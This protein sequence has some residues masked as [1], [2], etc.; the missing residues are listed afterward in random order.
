VDEAPDVKKVQVGPCTVAYH[1]SGAGTG[2]ILAHCSSASHRMWVPL[3]TDLQERYR[4]L[5]PDLIGYGKSDRWPA[6]Q[7]FDPSLD[8][9]VLVR[10]AQM[11]NGPVHIAAHSYGAAAALEAARQIADRVISLTLIEPVAFHLLPTAGRAEEWA[12]ISTIADGVWRA[13]SRGAGR[14]AAGIYMRFW[15]GRMRWWLMPRRQ[16]SRIIDTVGK[17]AAEFDGMRWVSTIPSDYQHIGAPTILMVGGRTRRPAKAVVEVLASNLPK[18]H[19]EVIP[20][21]GH[22]S[23]FTHGDEVRSKIITHINRQEAE[24]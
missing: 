24:R 11:V 19:V 4:V 13:A 10:L 8:A 23:P 16:R 17:V 3:I 22:M 14:V 2:V 20:T 6:D 1:D 18:A 21:A 15:I 7:R 9:E 12:E 5:A